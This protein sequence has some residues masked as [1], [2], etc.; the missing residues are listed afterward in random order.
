MLDLLNDVSEA[1]GNAPTPEAIATIKALHRNALRAS[2]APAHAML[3]LQD[4]LA[5]A[6]REARAATV[7]RQVLAEALQER[8]RRI[9]EL[10]VQVNAA[11]A[12]RG[13]QVRELTAEVEAYEAQFTT[14]TSERN[15]LRSA[16]LQLERQLKEA[17]RR[18]LEAERRCELLERQLA[19][20]DEKS[21]SGDWHS[22]KKAKI[23]LVDSKPENIMALRAILSTMDQDLLEAHSGEQALS[24]TASSDISIVLLSAEIDGS[25]D[26]F[27]IASHLKHRLRSRHIPIIFLTSV[28]HGPHYTFRGYAAGAADY[29]S[30]PVDPWVLRAKVA[31][32]VELSGRTRRRAIEDDPE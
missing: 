2:N 27:E 1:R 20:I 12:D 10:Q 11:E 7:E 29:I 17:T 3:L 14:L 21:A 4:Q 23:L 22:D 13:R 31:A 32:F 6:D 25:M 15:H 5:E 8:Q 19:M 26:G 9:A 16:I 28:K 18:H 30:K 24:I